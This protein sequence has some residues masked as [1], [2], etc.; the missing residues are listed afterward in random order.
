MNN[1]YTRSGR[2]TSLI[3]DEN[4]LVM[5]IA[6]NLI[7][8]VI[9]NFIEIAYLLGNT[10]LYQYKQD[11][12]QHVVPAGQFGEFIREPWTIITHLF[13]HEKVWPLIGNMLFLW[14][15]GFLLQDLS[16][17]RHLA[18]LYLYGGIVGLMV[19]LMSLNLIPRFI[20]QAASYTLAGAGAP[21]MAIAAAA[22]MLSPSYRIF[23]MIGGGIPLW[24]ITLVYVLIDLAGL[25]GSAFPYHL[26]HL[27][28]AGIGVLYV[29]ALRKGTDAGRWMH[30]L[31]TGFFGLFSS[32]KKKPSKKE[33]YYYDTKGIKPIHK[34]QHIT[35]QRIDALLDK[36]NQ[37]GLE[38]LTD[39]EKSF[40]NR[41]SDQA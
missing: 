17:P 24:I 31:Y 26:A 3:S 23:P 11:V 9:L 35:Q 2:K 33:N 16:G 30:R 38:S 10:E 15:F 20:P 36:I 39:E 22:T 5:L 41:I 4:P 27:S 13:A 40:L 29:Y 6:I 18:P 21:V 25:A 8:F 19:W 12:W 37:H 1:T 14:G 32:D 34:T 7:F 28:G